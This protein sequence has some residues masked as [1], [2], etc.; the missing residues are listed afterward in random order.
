MQMIADD[1]PVKTLIDG[2]DTF[3]GLHGDGINCIVEVLRACQDK[4]LERDAIITTQ[5]GTITTWVARYMMMR[6]DIKFSSSSNLATM[7]C[8][9]VRGLT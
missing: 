7:G 6:D 1:V 8:G 3:L 5:S 2:S 4:L 9:L